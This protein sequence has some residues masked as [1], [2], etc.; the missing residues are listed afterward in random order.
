MTT[1]QDL[2]K[3]FEMSDYKFIEQNHD[4]K[5]NLFECSECLQKSIIEDKSS[6][7]YVCDIC[8]LTKKMS[9]I[10]D[11]ADNV[12]HNGDTAKKDPSRC[13]KEDSIIQKKTLNTII[14]GSCKMSKMNQWTSMS[15]NE[16]TLW[17]TSEHIKRQCSSR[18]ISSNIINHTILLFKKINESKKG[19]GKK[20]IHRGKVRDGIIAACL[21]NAC[22][23]EN[24]ERTPVE[25]SEIMSVSLSDVNRGCKLFLDILSESEESNTE[26]PKSR[27]FLYRYGNMMGI[28][29]NILSRTEKILQIVLE[30]NILPNN[31]P[32]SIVAGVL[33]FVS[34]S[35]KLEDVN[36][37][38]LSST[39]NI[40][41]VTITKI[42]KLLSEHSDFL[43]S[44]F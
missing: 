12:Y 42:Y 27:D 29:Y 20:E 16:R 19:N 26:Q 31:T 28:Q 17:Q 39:C 7:F 4:D 6:G 18:N 23:K 30:N 40:S 32:S 36:K 13:G 10:D 5:E 8:G 37:K 25:I 9:I 14:N 3:M 43:M 24:S 35:L 44:Y 21:Y 15:Y 1:E 38:K 2:W 22:K 41:E 34:C 11:S 33:Y